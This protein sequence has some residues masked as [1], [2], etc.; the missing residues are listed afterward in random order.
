MTIAPAVPASVTPRPTGFLGTRLV[1]L[2]VGA[3]VQAAMNAALPGDVLKVPA[4]T[5]IP[6]LTVPPAKG[7]DWCTLLSGGETQLPR[8]GTTVAKTD[9]AAMIKTSGISAPAG[10]GAWRFI[11]LEVPR[12]PAAVGTVYALISIGRGSGRLAF[13]RCYAHGVV[14]L[15][16]RR[17]FALNGA[18][19]SILDTRIDEIHEPGADAQGICGWDG[20]GPYLIDGCDIQA[21]TENILFGGGDPSLAGLIPSDITIRRTRLS[22]DKSW[23]TTYPQKNLLEFKNARRV[24]V[25]NLDFLDF[26]GAPAI[27]IT[28]RNQD[29]NAPWCCVQDL[30][31]QN[32]RLTNVGEV[33]GGQTTD[34]AHP[35]GLVARVAIRNLLALGVASRF[36]HWGGGGGAVLED[37]ELTHNTV[38]PS[39]LAGFWL[40]GSGLIFRRLRFADNLLGAGSYVGQAVTAFTLAGTCDADSV[41]AKNGLVNAGDVDGGGPDRN[42]GFNPAQFISIPDPVA[43]GLDLSTG[44]LA[45]GSPYARAATDGGPLGV[46]PDAAPPTPTPVPV[47]VPVPPPPSPSPSPPTLEQRVAALEA[48][49]QAW[50]AVCQ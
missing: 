40:E 36:F 42:R 1:E 14:G 21:S 41:I 20:P 50:R 35:S 6:P 23:G 9:A 30:L 8:P 18:D 48:W 5:V 12:D 25:D 15:A 2:A 22:K 27:V 49:R 45:A 13:D 11:G 10:A 28:P 19:V 43:A 33:F 29:G 17:A 4:G 7:A 31:I 46:A 16:T 24:I 38:L 47:P 39:R 34:D 44:A 32:S 3:N 37:L 26:P